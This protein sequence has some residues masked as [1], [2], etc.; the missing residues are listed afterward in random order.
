MENERDDESPGEAEDVEVRA[1]I[2][3]NV[4]KFRFDLL[5]TLVDGN[6]EEEP[7]VIEVE[8]S[9]EAYLSFI[10]LAQR[11]GVGSPEEAF[12]INYEYA[13]GLEGVDAAVFNAL[14]L[15]DKID[16]LR[17]YAESQSSE[18]SDDDD[19]E[20]DDLGPWS[21]D[22]EFNGGNALTDNFTT[23]FEDSSDD[24]AF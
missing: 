13:A 7:E 23:S 9:R 24:N 1:F 20:G 5:R 4:E 10:Y 3:P 11:I 17:R 6:V 2:D 21:P 14:D 12:A 19:E 18:Q 22:Y 15:E 16:A 8:L